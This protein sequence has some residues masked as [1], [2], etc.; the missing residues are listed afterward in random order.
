[1][2]DPRVIQ[3]DGINPRQCTFR[4]VVAS[5]FSPP[6]LDQSCSEADAVLQMRCTRG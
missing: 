3:L 5:E 4:T 1:M 6:H 2:Q